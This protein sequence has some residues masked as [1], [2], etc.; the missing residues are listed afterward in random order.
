MEQIHLPAD[1]RH[2]FSPKYHYLFKDVLLSI[3]KMIIA[4]LHCFFDKFALVSVEQKCVTKIGKNN[5][6]ILYDDLH[7]NAAE[8]FSISRSIEVKQ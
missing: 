4:Y 5:A 8:V 3:T 6:S 1:D 2:Y 7:T